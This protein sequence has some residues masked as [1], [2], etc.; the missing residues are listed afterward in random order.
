[1]MKTANKDLFS[2]ASVECLFEILKI[3]FLL[4]ECVESLLG[5]FCQ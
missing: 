3:I 2:S 1:M 4:R 5:N